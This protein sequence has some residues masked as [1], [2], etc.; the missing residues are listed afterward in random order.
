MFDA[1]KSTSGSQE[2]DHILS[3]STDLF[4][5]YRQTLVTF[6]GFSAGKP[7]IDLCKLYGKWLRHYSELLVTKI[8]RDERKPMSDEDL[9]LVCI[10][11]NTA[12]YCANTTNQL[13]EKLIDT[14]DVEWKSQVSLS[15][16]NES[17]MAVS[18]TALSSLIKGV[19]SGLDSCLTL[20]IRKPWNTIEA[21]GDQSDY[22]TQI[23]MNLG[24]HISLIKKY[25]NSGRF[26]KSFC[27][28]FAE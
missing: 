15:S 9:K 17:F 25:T 2:D 14:I 5:Y 6:A 21:V 28:K 18:G 19:E 4:Y 23:A 16:E 12:E 27:D 26:F 3:S 22:I 20:M 1:Y 11:L 13:E 24:H 10:V 8:H 7:L